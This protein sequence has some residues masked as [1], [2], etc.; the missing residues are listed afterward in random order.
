MA[1]ELMNTPIQLTAVGLGPGDPEL[2]TVKGLR[3]IEAADV[4]FA[5]R[6]R[7]GEESRAL[8]IARPWIDPG[9]QQVVPLTIPMQ[10]TA[11]H[12][13]EVYH[14]IAAAIGARLGELAARHPQGVARGAYL[15]L[16]DPLLYG[17]FTTLWAELA[18]AYPQITVTIVP[19]ITSFAAAAARVGLPLSAGDDRM[20]ILP[21]PAEAGALRE[22]CVQFETV[23]LLKV[24]GALPQL[25]AVLDELAL[26]DD[27]VYAEHLGMPE[28]RI[29]REVGSLRGYAAPYLSL[30]IVRRGG[31]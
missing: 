17:T 4:V 23:V 2:V 12:A 25:V 29:V 5:P 10:R 20:A 13:P 30:L 19:G 31:R 28:E 21:A 1:K 24:G 6:S 15:L 9:R 7:D 8:R 22:L 26:L 11:L 18:A 16:G 14:G 27:A 3:A